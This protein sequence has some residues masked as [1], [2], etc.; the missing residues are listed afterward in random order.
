VTEKRDLMIFLISVIL[1]T[2]LMLS[3]TSLGS[4]QQRRSFS[5]LLS[6]ERE[7]HFEISSI[8]PGSPAT[9]E[10]DNMCIRE[11]TVKADENVSNVGLTL[12]QLIMESQPEFFQ[13]VYPEI[14]RFFDFTFENM[15]NAQVENVIVEFGVE[16]SWISEH[17]IS[18][19]NITF[20]RVENKQVEISSPM[21]EISREIQVP[22]PLPTSRLGENATH[23]Y[24]TSHS[25]SFSYFAI[26]REGE[27]ELPENFGPGENRPDNMSGLDLSLD[28]AYTA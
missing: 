20:A 1:V 10:I 17:S 25:P 6:E 9:V 19:E 15:T 24:F 22:V 3:T 7:S 28:R 26:T 8:A 13:E 4:A 18:E 23:I 5:D 12:R 2:F 27:T 14:Y 11:L 21:G 16:K